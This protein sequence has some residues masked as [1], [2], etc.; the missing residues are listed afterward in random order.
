M[1]PIGRITR[2][3]L[4]WCLLRRR[5]SWDTSIYTERMQSSMLRC[6]ALRA[7]YPC[8]RACI[9]ASCTLGILFRVSLVCFVLSLYFIYSRGSMQFLGRIQYHALVTC[10]VICSGGNEVEGRKMNSLC[11]IRDNHQRWSK[12]R[13]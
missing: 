3:A 2:A 5:C 6:F 7:Q 12:S 1:S 11:C 10:L 4:K 9:L 13:Q 8:V